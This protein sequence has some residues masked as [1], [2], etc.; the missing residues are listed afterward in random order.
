MNLTD[1][2]F[3]VFSWPVRANKTKSYTPPHQEQGA[4]RR[5]HGGGLTCAGLHCGGRSPHSVLDPEGEAAEHQAESSLDQIY[6]MPSCPVACHQLT[7]TFVSYHPVTYSIHWFYSGSIRTQ[8]TIILLSLQK[9]ERKK[10]ITVVKACL[11]DHLDSCFDLATHQ[12]QRPAW[13]NLSAAP[14]AYPKCWG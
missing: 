11:P 2:F 7:W 14:S 6:C 4:E 5:A 8:C 1:F 10:N 12:I 13:A 9:K 3:Y